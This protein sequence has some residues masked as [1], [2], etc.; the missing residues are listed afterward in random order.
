[1]AIVD[2]VVILA[3]VLVAITLSVAALVLMGADGRDRAK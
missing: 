3:G 2:T 1:M